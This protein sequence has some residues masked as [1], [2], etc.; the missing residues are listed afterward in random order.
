MTGTKLRI[1]SAYER[2]ILVVLLVACNGPA[3]ALAQEVI[4]LDFD[5]ARSRIS[6]SVEGF[7]HSVQ[8]TFK[9]KSGRVRL[10]MTS[11]KAD[12]AVVVDATSGIS[13]NDWRDRDMRRDILQ[14]ERYPEIIFA[15]QS[16]VLFKPESG[17]SQVKVHG[18]LTLC[19]AGHPVDLTL[20]LHQS[21]SSVAATGR[22]TI[23]YVAWGLKDPSL[24]ILR[25]SKNVGIEL[26]AVARVVPISRS[27][28]K[29]E[30]PEAVK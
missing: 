21:D 26:S 24:L 2:A 23:P 19:G 20:S 27:T 1:A 15:P 30:N 29:V 8:G 16:F 28:A 9:M 3:A 10:D 13:G 12:G 5:T 4:A 25:I 6:F 14:S 7:P 17:D 11:G 18:I 22:I